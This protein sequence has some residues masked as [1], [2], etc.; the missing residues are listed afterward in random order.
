MQFKALAFQA[1][2]L[3]PYTLSIVSLTVLK[4]IPKR[5]RYTETASSGE[6]SNSSILSQTFSL[7]RSRPFWRSSKPIK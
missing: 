2:D 5:V 7:M 1:F 4:G 6:K 3:C